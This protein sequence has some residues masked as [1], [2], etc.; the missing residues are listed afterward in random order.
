[1][2]VGLPKFIE[3]PILLMVRREGMERF[4]CAKG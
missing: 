1:M 3:D 4:Y 2:R